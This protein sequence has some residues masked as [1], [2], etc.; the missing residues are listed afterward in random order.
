MNLQA[1]EAALARLPESY[2]PLLLTFCRPPLKVIGG[3]V[4]IATDDRRESR[5]DLTD[6]RVSAVDPKSDLPALFVNSSMSQLEASVD[7]YR[8]YAGRVR[9][10]DDDDA[11]R[12]VEK[13]RRRLEDLDG[14]ANANPEGWWALILEQAH[15]GLL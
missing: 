13:L 3:A 10:A 6:G 14:N 11:T 7:A 9:F 5:V 12:L 2:E 4:V 15:A 1:I 8:E